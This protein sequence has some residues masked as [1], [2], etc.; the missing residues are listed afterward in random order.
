MNAVVLELVAIPARSLRRAMIWWALGIAALVAMTMSVWPAFEGSSGISQAM[1]QLPAGVVQAFGLQDFGTPAGFLRANLYDFFVPLLVA[2]AA[3]MFVNGQTAGEESAGRLELYFAQPV[4]RRVQ[5]A[6]R[7]VAAGLALVALVAVLLAVQVASDA[8]VGLRIDGAYVVAT[9]VL[10]GLLAAL[11]GGLALA[12]AGWRARP[13]L[14]LGIG[15]GSVF[16][17]LVVYSLFPLSDVLSP[18]RHISPWDWAF[19]GAPLERGTEIW[20]YLALAVPAFAL[21]AFGVFAVSRRDVTG[22]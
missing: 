7:A 3:V 18:W 21:A 13:S 22:G 5:F 8:A 14:V 11:H 12:L 9:I 16:A 19:G 4:S 20:R 10:T 1:D 17:G 15:L 6:G 2:V